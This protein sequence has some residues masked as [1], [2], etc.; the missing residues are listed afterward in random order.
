MLVYRRT[1]THVLIKRTTHIFADKN[2]GTQALIYMTH[3]VVDI[4]RD[5]ENS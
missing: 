4:Q 2:K 5:T 3:T 1:H